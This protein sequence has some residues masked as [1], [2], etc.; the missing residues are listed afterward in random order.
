MPA[1]NFARCTSN[2]VRYSHIPILRTAETRQ[3]PRGRLTR[4]SD[5]RTEG[6]TSK[7]PHLLSAPVRKEESGSTLSRRKGLPLLNTRRPN[8]LS[9]AVP[10]PL[11]CRYLPDWKDR[12]NLAD[13]FESTFRTHHLRSAT[14]LHLHTFSCHN[15][16]PASARNHLFNQDSDSGI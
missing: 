3:C 6:G 10:H 16:C 12:R 8:L 14:Q 1:T 2:P 9:P 5:E 11:Q 4:L 13:T 15:L 7:P